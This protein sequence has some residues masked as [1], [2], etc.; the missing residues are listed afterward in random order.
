MKKVIL[1]AVALLMVCAAKAQISAGDF[2]WGA[3]VGLNA[4]NVSNLDA[5][6]KMSFHVGAFAEWKLGDFV[7]ISPE[8]VYSRQGARYKV[9]G[10]KFK[11]RVNYLNIPV[12][13]KLYVLECL[14]VDLGPQFGL[15]FNDVAKWK[16]GS[17]SGKDKVN[18]VN[19]FDVSFPVG[20]SY[21]Y[22]G[23]VVS[24]RYNIGLTNVWKKEDVGFNTK[25]HVFQFSVGYCLSDLF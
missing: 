4:T 22:E 8:L 7:G 11:R 20:I 1:M 2:V 17:S 24:A 9:D 12:L 21:A 14:S 18:T 5:K 13:A 25:N 19:T 15:A 23:F 16:N 10:N 3:K 6:N